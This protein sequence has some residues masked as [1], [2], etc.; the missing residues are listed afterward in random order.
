MVRKKPLHQAPSRST[1]VKPILLSLALLV[2][3]AGVVMGLVQLLV[4]S[5][6]ERGNLAQAWFALSTVAAA[7][8]AGY[9]AS[10]A[11]RETQRQ[12][13]HATSPVF[14][15]LSPSGPLPAGE[16]GISDVTE[17]GQRER[18]SGAP[19]RIRAPARKAMMM[20]LAGQRASG[21]PERPQGPRINVSPGFA[22]SPATMQPE[23]AFPQVGETSVRY[24]VQWW[25]ILADQASREDSDNLKRKMGATLGDLRA[26][27]RLRRSSATRDLSARDQRRRRRRDREKRWCS[28]KPFLPAASEGSSGRKSSW[29]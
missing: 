1:Q 21:A 28:V 29:C 9:F 6:D 24:L 2:V 14:I 16:R 15:E 19:K 4:C 22:A 13:I 12:R 5:S 27:I 20:L 3:L 10:L 7:V 26:V 25:K 23:L 17:K 11:A 18:A 8:I